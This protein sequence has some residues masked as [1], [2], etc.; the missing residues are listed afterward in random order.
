[1]RDVRPLRQSTRPLEA[2]TKHFHQLLDGS[3]EAVLLTD[4]SGAVLAA[5]P[6]AC[7]LLGR[8]EHELRGLR[9][10]SLVEA[11]DPPVEP[12]DKQSDEGSLLA[13]MTLV[14]G[15]GTT[16]LAEVVR[17]AVLTDNGAPPFT[18]LIVRDLDAQRSDQAELQEYR[19]RFDNLCDERIGEMREVAARVHQEAEERCS[20]EAAARASE[21]RYRLLSEAS[22]D[23]IYI[24]GSDLSVRYVNS[25]AAQHFGMSAKRLVGKPL[26]ELFTG[27]V[28]ARIVVAVERVL[29]SGKPYEADGQIA[30]PDD[31]RWVNTRLV[32]L[33][34]GDRVSG[35]LGVSHDIT[36]RKRAQDALAESE[37]RYRSLFED[38]PVA[39]W[40]EDHSA[41]KAYVGQLLS[42]GV[43][44]VAKYLREQPAEYRHCLSLVRTLAVNQA[45]VALF[46]A[47]SPEELI[48]RQTELYPRG[49]VGGLPSFWAAIMAGARSALYEE[50]NRTLTGRRLQVLETCTVAPGYEERCD[51]I[52]LADVDVSERQRATELL[53]KYQLL[54][55]EAR[56]VMLYART[57]D[58]RII[59]ANA[60]A[61]R[62]YGYSREELLQLSVHDLRRDSPGPSLAEQ[63]AAAVDGGIV[64]E[65]VHHRKDGSAVPV[66]VSSRGQ[67][68]IA[69]DDVILSVIRDATVR[70]EA[71]REVAR[72]AARRVAT[73][74]AVVTAL[75]SMAELR[76]PFVAGHQRRVAALACAIA[77]ELAWGEERIES[78]RTAALLHDIGKIVVPAEILSKPGKLSQIEFELIRQ[79]AGVGGEIL[80]DIDFED[81]VAGM[82]C[83]HHERLDGS[84]YPAGLKTDEILPEARILAVADV[85]EAM[86]SH[87]PYRPALPLEAALSEIEMGRG[88]RYDAEAC[89]ACLRLMR[90]Q[91]FAF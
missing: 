39:M 33:K 76:D 58:G 1:M 30:Y 46:E 91:R 50:A 53:D 82:V 57:T 66:E 48:E 60:A 81:D 45:A 17:G 75:G 87:R 63:V 6:A 8:S 12:A 18:P 28:A 15:D 29:A 19:Q 55:K 67:T 72:T 88:C 35:V 32:A 73:L 83:Q 2:Q 31:L 90:E 49:Y 77:G 61:E 34:D 52:Y 24:V 3:R 59:E 40:E 78:L 27:P 84:G 13:E 22:P 80:A 74:R 89:D 56:D 42:R 47:S 71:E 43:D 37:R 7:A 10:G 36:E 86:I 20:A 69:G 11:P 70:K 26:A 62:T 16:F 5:N 4:Q 85:V 9:Y 79:H 25:K 68:T 38:S 65:T 41:V 64:F 44:D 23:M 14:R 51:R 54:A 21:A